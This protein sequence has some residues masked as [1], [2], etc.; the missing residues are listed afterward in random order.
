[1]TYQHVTKA[2]KDQTVN[3]VPV[4]K[5]ITITTLRLCCNWTKWCI[6]TKIQES[7]NLSIK[8]PN[9]ER[10]DNLHTAPMIMINPKLGLT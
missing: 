2:L 3:F 10:A 8:A 1:M 7:H 4:N 5:K 6:E 9:A